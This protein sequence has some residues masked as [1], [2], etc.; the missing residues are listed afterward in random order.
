[1]ENEINTAL[2]KEQALQKERDKKTLALILLNLDGYLFSDEWRRGY[3]AN[4][5]KRLAADFTGWETD[6]S[7]FEHQFERVIK[8]L[9]PDDGAREVPPVSKL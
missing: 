1:V 3:R 9:R 2:E 4:I 8:A 6:N 5:R 7:K